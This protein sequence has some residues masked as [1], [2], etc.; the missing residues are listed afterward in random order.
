ML[1]QPGNRPLSICYFVVISLDGGGKL[2]TPAAKPFGLS[3]NLSVSA[4]NTVFIL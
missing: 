3:T 2:K 4:C 1:P